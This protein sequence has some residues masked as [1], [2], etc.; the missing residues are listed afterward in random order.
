MVGIALLGAGIFAREQH[1]PAIESVPSLSLK[2]IYSRSES[3]ANTL[4]SAASSPVDVYYDVPTAGSGSG[5]AAN[6]E[7]TLDALLARTD[8][9]A[10]VIALPILA[11]PAVIEKALKAGKHVLSE[12]PVA[13]DVEEAK[14]L[15]GFYEAL[16]LDNNKKKPLWAVAE[17]FR[18]TPSL[19]KAAEKVKEIGGKLTTFRLNMNGWVEEGNKYFK[20]EWRKVPSYQ[21]GFLLD[22]GVHFIAGLRLLLSELNQEITHVAGFSALLEERLLP[23]DT[24]HAV[25]LTN[26]GKSGTISISFGTQFKTGLEVEVVTT[27]GSVYWNPTQIK[28]KTKEGEETE[29]FEKS[30]GVKE[31]MAAFAKAI[32]KGQ[33]EKEQTPEE[34]LKDLEVVQRLLESGEGKGIVKAVE[35]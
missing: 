32:E 26:D 14:R 13:K 22:G 25:A 28:T 11:Q 2:A 24:V 12:K 35:A 29:E 27:Q 30:T 31:E 4:A 20:T 6:V 1:L 19:L 18:Y 33:T 7:K 21:G 15:V 10:V 8:I 17:N 23:V 3:S 9:D 34:A 16:D 5:E